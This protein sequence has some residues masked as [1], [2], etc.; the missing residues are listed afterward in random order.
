MGETAA[1]EASGA[2][3][4]AASAL[5]VSANRRASACRCGSTSTRKL[6]SRPWTARNSSRL[7][8]L[9]RSECERAGQDES[10]CRDAP[11][12]LPDAVDV[13]LDGLLAVLIG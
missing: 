13:G 4:F 5:A 8:C 7:S 6:P 1:S 11:L 9:F 12:K 3:S 10:R 2:V